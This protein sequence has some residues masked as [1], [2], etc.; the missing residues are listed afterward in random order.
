MEAA[1]V[2]FFPDNLHQGL[3][4]GL[5][6][7]NYI[8][9]CLKC[10]KKTYARAPLKMYSKKQNMTVQQTKIILLPCFKLC[11]TKL[12]IAASFTH[13][14][15]QASKKTRHITGIWGPPSTL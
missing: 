7:N 6:K 12:G 14:K 1:N 4:G 8:H 10:K 5:S 11:K 13:K 9:T 3:P 2:A 15:G